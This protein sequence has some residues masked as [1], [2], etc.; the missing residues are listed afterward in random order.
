MRVVDASRVG[1]L[2]DWTDGWCVSAFLSVHDVAGREDGDVLRVKNLLR[3]AEN[4][5]IQLG[6]RRAEAARLVA[7]DTPEELTDPSSEVFHRAGVAIFAAP[8]L[9]RSYQL[10]GR[11]PT[12]VTVARRFHLKPL[13]GMLEHDHPFVVLA[14]T[15]GC[16]QLFSGDSSGL[17]PIDVPDMPSSLDD[18]V[19]YDDRERALLSHSASRSGTGGVVAAFHGQGDRNDYL[20][21]DMMRYLRMVDASLSRVIDESDRLVLAGSRDVV[22][23]YRGLSSRGALVEQDV[24]GN[25]EAMTPDDLHARASDAVEAAAGR[26][27]EA[28]AARFHQLHGTGKASSTPA[29][30]IQAARGGR[31]ETM[32]VASDEQL[33]GRFE[34][35]ADLPEVHDTRMPG[36]EDLFD[37]AT[38]DAWKAGAAVHVVPAA[39][40]PGGTGV[41][42]VFRF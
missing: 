32:F 29:T 25:P 26:S 2:A 1:E 13:L 41:A 19:Q 33:W 22:A 27:T 36:D 24:L 7:E 15:R 35:V 23:L 17:R 21:E 37:T 9:H 39:A 10:T 34:D 12:L 14:V 28:D 16:A 3:D 31:V 18:A 38:V 5:L 40:V 8:D 20:S 11:A 6:M 4:E 30:V 42:A